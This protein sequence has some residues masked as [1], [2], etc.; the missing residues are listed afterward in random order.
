MKLRSYFKIK[1]FVEFLARKMGY[2]LVGEGSISDFKLYPRKLPEQISLQATD[3]YTVPISVD[4]SNITSRV[5][6]SFSSNDWHPF[7][8]TLK[9]YKI[10]PNLRYEDSTLAKLYNRYT[11]QNVQEV[12]TEQIP[13]PQKPFCDWPPK[14]QFITWVWTL[15]QNRVVNIMNYIKGRCETNGWIYFGPHDITYGK[16]EFDRLISLY[17]SIKKDG[18]ASTL[19]D[20]DPV[21]GYFLKKGNDLKFVLLQGNH[22]VSVLKALEYKTVKILIRKGHPAVV[23]YEKLHLWTQGFGGIYPTILIEQLFNNLF[24]G[25]GLDKAKR[26]GLNH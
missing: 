26:Y 12:L 14:Y 4:I 15:N 25:S 11:P 16:K 7:V 20:Q 21:N 24:Y 13:T 2:E 17:N 10:N 3:P 1:P 18:F 6:F 5:G 8:Q 23:G 22:R 9:E 19:S